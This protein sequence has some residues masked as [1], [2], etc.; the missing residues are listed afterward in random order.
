MKEYR[1]DYA[2]FN[3]MFEFYVIAENKKEAEKKFIY[4]RGEQPKIINIEEVEEIK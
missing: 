4:L 3:N 1:I 2:I